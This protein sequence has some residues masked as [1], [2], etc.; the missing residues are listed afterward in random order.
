M[1]TTPILIWNVS[2]FYEPHWFL[3]HNVRDAFLGTG[4]SSEE[5]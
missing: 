4:Y 3:F 1:W 2:Q 5:E